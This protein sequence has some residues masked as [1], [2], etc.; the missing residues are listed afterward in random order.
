MLL[1][2]YLSCANLAPFIS[3]SISIPATA[4]GKSPTGVRTEYLP[5]ILSGITNVSYF[6]FVASFFK[7]PSFLSVVTY[8]LFLASSK[9]YF[10]SINSLNILNAIAG[11]VVVP[12]FDITFIEKSFP[13]N[14]SITSF[15]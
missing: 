11:S 13:D 15:I 8:I 2:L 6:S 4:I 7:A 3:S 14:K 1:S 10:D 12:D 9:P 5:P